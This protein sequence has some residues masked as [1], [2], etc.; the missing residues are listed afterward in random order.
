MKSRWILNWS[1]HATSLGQPRKNFLYISG[2]YPCKFRNSSPSTFNRHWDVLEGQTSCSNVCSQEGS[3]IVHKNPH[4]KSEMTVDKVM[5][6]ILAKTLACIHTHPWQ[7]TDRTWN[8]ELLGNV[9][10]SSPPHLEHAWQRFF[11]LRRRIWHTLPGIGLVWLQ[12]VINRASFTA[13]E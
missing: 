11:N 10:S 8:P 3:E 13:G 6:A 12:I 9:F 7:G 2:Y 1:L 4:V 5:H